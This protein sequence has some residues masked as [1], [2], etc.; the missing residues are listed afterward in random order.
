MHLRPLG[1]R[2]AV[3]LDPRAE[4]TDSGL[5]L[6]DTRDDEDR[7]TARVL[8]VGPG[9]KCPKCGHGH[10][11]DLALGQTV[12]LGPHSP[13]QDVTIGDETVTLVN[14]SDVIG[15]VDEEPF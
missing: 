3:T 15:V 4:R 12:L 5:Y 13:V 7:L 6:P 14:A 9:A 1:D 8:A 2:I 11:I 10:A